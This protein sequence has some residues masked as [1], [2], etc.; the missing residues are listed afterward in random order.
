[1]TLQ[2]YRLEWLVLVLVV[3][4]TIP[5]V[6]VVGAQDSTRIALTD[7]VLLRGKVDIDPYWKLTTDRAFKGGH[8]YTDKAPGMSL[9]ALPAVE[10][11][12]LADP[13]LVT[14]SGGTKEAWLSSWPLWGMRLW[15][16]GLAFLALVF[17]FGRVAEGLVAGSG[18][19]A[20]TTLGVGTMAG[21][22][23]PT[24]FGHVPDALALLVAFVVATRARRPRDWIC[25]GLAA[26]VGVLFEYPAGLA[27]LVLVGYAAARSGCRAALATILGGIP[28]AIL[29]GAY[30]WLAFGAPWRLSYRYTDNVFTSEQQQNLFGVGLPSGHGIWTLLLDGHGL[31]LVSPVLVMAVAGLVRFGRAARLEAWTAGLIAFLFAVYTAGYFLPNGGLSPGPRFATVA[32]PFL[33]L[34]LPFALARWRWPTL[35]LA[36]AS[37]GVALFDELTW[38]VANKLEFVTWPTTIW[39]LMGL[40]R[41]EGCT[42]LLACGGLAGIVGLYGA[43]RRRPIER[44]WPLLQSSA[45]DVR[46]PTADLNV[47]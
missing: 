9:L 16:G 6:G 23:G 27:A 21:S 3:L 25:V 34:G 44:P 14:T 19:A 29:L 11:V 43:L 18:A 10:V 5:L 30:D 15:A 40:S 42:I 17:L 7:S 33:L 32:L 45:V 47:L 4:A 38:S 28:P 35:L 37:V 36:S 46:S 8:W 22:L 13:K 39:S 1:M 20:A 26:G 31:L 12:R 41:R 2:A 24:L